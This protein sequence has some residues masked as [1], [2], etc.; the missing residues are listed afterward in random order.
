MK[1]DVMDKHQLTSLI[2][3]PMSNTNIIMRTIITFCLAIFSIT[4]VA[5]SIGDTIIVPT[6]NYTQT[7]GWPWCGFS[8][9]TMIDFPDNPDVSYEKIIMAYNMRCKDGLVSVPGYTNMGCGEWDYSCNTYITDS[10]R[11]D[12]V[13]SFTNSHYISAFT[14]TTYNYVEVPLYDYYQ[15]RQKHVQINNTISE[16]LNTVGSGNMSLSHVLAT[17]NNSGKS[18]YLYTHAELSAAGI[19]VGDIDGFLL[20]VVNSNADA[21]YLQVKVKHTNK[22]ALDSNDPDNDGFTEVYFHDYSLS[23]G[24]N[25]IQFHTPFTWNGTSNIIVEFSFTNNNTSNTLDVEGENTGI[26]SGIYSTNGFNLNA[27]NGK[28]DIPTGAF[29]S[30]SDEITISFWSY[31]NE[32]VQPIH[33]SIF[34]GA[35]NNNK[36]QVNLHHPWGNS[37]IY[38]DCGNDGTGYDRIDKTATPIEFKG[39]WSHWAVTK[40]ASSGDMKIYHN[41][42]LW[43]SG[44]NKNRLIDI[45]KFILGTSGNPNR[46]Y[47]GKIDEFRIWDAELNEQTIQD[48]MHK[49]VEA[50]HPDYA[51]LVAYYKMDEGSGNTIADSSIHAES[52]II[53]GFMYWLYEH[54]SKL[55][56]GFTGITERPNLTFAQ[57]DYNLSITDQIVTDS[58]LLTPNIVREYN[59]LPRYGTMLHD[60][61]N[62]ISVNEFWEAQYQHIYDPE[63]VLI[64]SINVVHTGTIEI[65]KLSYFKRYPCKY[66]ILSFVTPYGIYLDLGMEGKTWFFDVTDYAPILKG[67]KRMTIERGGEWQEDMDIKFFYIVGTPPHDII[68]INQIWRADSKSYTAI[69]DE[70]AFE[71]RDVYFNPE[72]S[73]FKI[74]S[75]IT[76]HGQ[77]GEFTPRHHTLNI[78][79]GEIEY[80][81]IVWTECS[82]IPIYPQ[83]GTWIY[84][85]AGWCPGDPSDLYEFDITEHVSAG[86]THTIDY[87]M[88]YASGTSNYIVNNQ[89]VTYG[90]PNF[91]LD[92]AIVRIMKPNSEDA[93]QERFN[94][95]CSYPEIIIQN[96]GTTTLTSLD[97]E[98][99][100]EGGETE[101]YTWTGSLEFLE[102]NTVVLPIPELTFWLGTTDR[103]IV[104][105]SN[106]NEQEDEY[107]YNNTCSSTFDEIH[108]Y[109]EGELIAIRLKTNNLGYQTSYTL[110]DGE[111]NVYYE[112][113]NCDNNTIYNDEFLLDPGCYKLRIDDSGDNGLEFWH[114]PNQGVGFFKIKD[115]DGGI[116]YTFD[117]DFGNFAVFEFGIGN[118]TKID[119]VKTPFII[120]FYPN[121]TSDKITVKVVGSG[122]STLSIKLTNS[123]M[124][125]IIEKEWSVKNEEFDTEIDMKHLPAGI[126]FLHIDYGNYSKTEKIIKY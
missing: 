106:P 41:G 3:K 55:T 56:R 2:F 61:I 30:I 14:G 107:S 99:L 7:H 109:P 27:V 86:Q 63:G 62:E 88:V 110:Y 115:S 102:K 105:I 12:S 118:I 45:Q 6:Y 114:Q 117:P 21:E 103:F 77:Q 82:T 48:W 111:G 96:T 22:T 39:S 36:R 64:D 31:G 47:F 101:S 52:A 34:H 44:T 123:V 76:G 28:V 72:G 113:G 70:K 91:N 87:G 17:D 8:R 65:S 43:H 40:N 93:S 11:V 81:W 54:G 83:G 57:G 98:Y 60:S 46:S 120:S 5:Q 92:A 74:R 16:T 104:T 42:E 13:L 78:N 121:P 95:V 100:V 35:D 84:D 67:K 85:R 51:N 9:D 73:L 4:V 20:N 59:I 25:R 33:N 125:K 94:P 68:D 108:V 58:V 89:L 18:Q 80:D 10:S 50:S 38:F 112:R 122:N 1:A 71:A 23:A 32:E 15:Y 53:E 116:L 24:S 69:K 119:K 90:E 75:V 97:I 126:Y 49:P 26:V 124:A 66:D 79:G 19:L 37:G 29:S